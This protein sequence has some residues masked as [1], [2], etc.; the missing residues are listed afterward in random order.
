MLVSMSREV[1]PHV[2]W[3]FIELCYTIVTSLAYFITSVMHLALTNQDRVNDYDPN[4]PQNTYPAS[5]RFSI[6]YY[7]FYGGYIAGGVSI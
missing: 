6:E 3:T 5:F 7:G 2:H 1:F 4:R